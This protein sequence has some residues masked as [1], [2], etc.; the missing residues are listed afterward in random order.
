MMF[1]HAK[2]EKPKKEKEKEEKSSLEYMHA[3]KI[4]IPHRANPTTYVWTNFGF[5]ELSWIKK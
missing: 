3:F 5:K 1:P 4:D 2:K